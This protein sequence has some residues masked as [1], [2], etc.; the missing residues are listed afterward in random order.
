MYGI[1]SLAPLAS[2]TLVRTVSFSIYTHSN[3]FYGDLLQKVFGPNAVTAH[4]AEDSGSLPKPGDAVRWAMSGAT[5]GAAI[6]AIA[7]KYRYLELHP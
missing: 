6:T 3:G 4:G 5:A 7:C 2:V 1:G